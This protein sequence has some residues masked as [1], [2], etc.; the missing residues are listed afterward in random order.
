MGHDG[1]FALRVT[2]AKH[3]HE[4]KPSQHLPKT[5]I[6]EGWMSLRDA[7]AAQDLAPRTH[8]PTTP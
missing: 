5:W 7:S 2:N 1:P 6:A 8:H 3:T 4:A